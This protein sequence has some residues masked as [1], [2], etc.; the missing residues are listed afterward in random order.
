M[1]NS[2]GPSEHV[3]T[4]EVTFMIFINPGLGVAGFVSALLENVPL[5]LE[6]ILL[7][8]FYDVPFKMP[9]LLSFIAF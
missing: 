7:E 5:G 1:L 6:S 8:T 3:G 2:T 9:F 4:M